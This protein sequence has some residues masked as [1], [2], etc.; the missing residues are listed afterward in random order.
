MLFRSI[1][2][3]PAVSQIED[4]DDEEVTTP[5]KTKK[6]KAGAP[7]IDL[8]KVVCVDSNDKKK[9][10]DSWFPALVVSP[11]AQ[12]TAKIRPKDEFLVRSF[13]DGR[14]YTVPKKEL[15]I[16]TKDNA[17]LDSSSS[18]LRTAIESAA[19]YIEKD[20]LPVHWDREALLSPERS[21]RTADLD[22]ADASEPDTAVEDVGTTGDK[23]RFLLEL[24][25]FM[26]AK[27][28]PMKKGPVVCNKE[29]NLHKLFEA[30]REKG[31]YTKV[32]GSNQWKSVIQKIGFGTMPSTSTI[33]QIKQAYKR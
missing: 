17:K 31:G 13:K 8:G 27:G 22:S 10:K 25:K 5:R 29:L 6:R 2:C 4:S 3:R 9:T 32:S 18:A 28:T 26:E 20:E 7:G 12:E 1:V 16:F 30:V 21:R 15:T 24:Q 33:N 11:L 19:K 14:F 23:K